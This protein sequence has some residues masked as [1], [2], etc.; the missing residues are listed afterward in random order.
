MAHATLF[1]IINSLISTNNSAHIVNYPLQKSFMVPSSLGH[2]GT[3]LL[4]PHRKIKTWHVLA[5]SL[6]GLRPTINYKKEKKKPSFIIP[7]LSV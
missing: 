4:S 2:L 7:C 3:K 6:Q 1:S 5:S